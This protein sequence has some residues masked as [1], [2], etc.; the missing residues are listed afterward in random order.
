MHPFRINFKTLFPFLFC[1]FLITP[2]LTNAAY[3]DNGLTTI[4]TSTGLEW[5]DLTETSG[6]A[7]QDVANELRPGGAF[8]GYK[9]A[10]G[11]E[12]L[13]LFF[14]FGLERGPVNKTHLTFIDLFGV[15]S[16]R[17][18]NDAVGYAHT[19]S[20]TAGVYGLN[21]MSYNREELYDVHKGQLHHST[22]TSFEGFGSFLVRNNTSYHPVPE[23]DASSTALALGFLLLCHLIIRERRYSSAGQEA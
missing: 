20:P 10:E 3:I 13:D 23:I 11:Q 4:D 14:G 17:G 2:T 5:L 7:Y 12:I 8:E 15:T 1:F 19:T 18:E 22:S 21:H 16:T 9:H 6:I